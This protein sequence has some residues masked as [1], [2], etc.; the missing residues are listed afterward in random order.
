MQ[1][2]S[3]FGKNLQAVLYKDFLKTSDKAQP[4]IDAV[5]KANEEH[6]AK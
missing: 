1:K 6:P 3:N 2:N 4:L 5:K